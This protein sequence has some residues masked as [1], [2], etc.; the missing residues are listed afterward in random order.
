MKAKWLFKDYIENR[1]NPF[2]STP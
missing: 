2:E 1:W